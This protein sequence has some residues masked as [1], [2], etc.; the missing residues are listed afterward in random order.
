MC[1]CGHSHKDVME[2][3]HDKALFNAVGIFVLNLV[4]LLSLFFIESVNWRIF[5]AFVALFI[6]C[7][8]CFSVKKAVDVKKT[9]E[10]MNS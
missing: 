7:C 5:V 10:W 8:F 2:E 9:Q 6:F 1:G 3:E 4:V